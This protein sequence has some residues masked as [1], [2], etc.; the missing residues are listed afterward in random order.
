MQ[1]KKSILEWLEMYSEAGLKTAN[2][3]LWKAQISKLESMGFEVK[4]KPTNRRSEYYCIIDWRNPK[5]DTVAME[6]YEIAETVISA[7]S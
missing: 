4:A 3:R 1:E 2:R 7:Q 5:K 6:L